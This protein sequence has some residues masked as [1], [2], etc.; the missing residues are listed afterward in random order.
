MTSNLWIPYARRLVWLSALTALVLGTPL[1]SVASNPEAAESQT[2]EYRETLDDPPGIPAQPDPDAPRVSTLRFGRFTTN[3]VNVDANGANIPGD[4]ANEPSIA[5]D[6]TNPLR[7][8]IGWRQF[9]TITS[10]FRQA[11]NAFSTDGGRT[12]TNR[13]PLTPGIFR[14]DPVLAFDQDGIFY[15][16]SL[17]GDL[18]TDLFTSTDGGSSWAGPVFAFGGDKQWM[19]VDRTGGAA[20]GFLYQTWSGLGDPNIF[21]RSTDSGASFTGP[22]QVPQAPKWGTIDVADDGTVYL[23][24][25][26]SPSQIWVAWS[27]DAQNP[28]VPIPSFNITQVD[29]GG[30]QPIAAG[31]NPEGLLGQLWLGIDRS[32]GPTSG[33]L[34]LCGSIDPI[35][36]D[37]V[38]VLFSRSTDGGFTWSSPVR[39][40]DDV[41]DHW[42]W[43]AT[44]SVAPN[45]RIDV[46]WNDNR[47]TPLLDRISQLYYS[48]STDGGVTWS[49]NEVASPSWDAHIGWPNQNKIGDYYHMISDNVGAD[50]AWAATFNG[51]QDVYHTR[52]GDYDCNGNGV[53]DSLDVVL[54]NE[55]DVNGNGILDVCEGIVSDVPGTPQIDD[56]RLDS[57]PNPFKR[58]TQ[59]IFHLPREGA[60]RLDV[61][62]AQGR[63][64]RT[65]ADETYTAGRH[66]VAWDG[67]DGNGRRLPPGVYLLQA[68]VGA[69]RQ[70][71]RVVV[72]R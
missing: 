13:P 68:R 30:T 4:A 32:A 59:V 38:D 52:I 51:E 26:S 9:D 46:V 56:L 7:M 35:G 43:F 70:A 5:I 40:N 1:D 2:F 34:Y 37:P 36:L 24:G 45:G 58:G 12:W 53:G 23:T 63:L 54:G 41:G 21:N 69:E 65:L 15:Y 50:L 28:A 20:D 42:Q 16:N 60:A 33:Y 19:T 6:P 14:S 49:P 25:S 57:Y 10:N 11:G 29:F 47:A 17:E 55:T 18:T 71:R 67:T 22:T 62:D 8:V 31:P 44:M 48:S 39:I 66:A 27:S 72:L 3:Q 61:L 64:L